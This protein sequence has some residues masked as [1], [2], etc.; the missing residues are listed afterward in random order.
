MFITDNLANFGDKLNRFNSTREFIVIVR[1]KTI[2]AE[3]S[4]ALK[5]MEN[6]EHNDLST[7]YIA[8]SDEVKKLNSAMKKLV[9]SV[10]TIIKQ[11]ASIKV[12]ATRELRGLSKFFPDNSASVSSG[13]ITS[14]EKDPTTVVVRTKHQKQSTR[15]VTGPV[16][17]TVPLT[18]PVT[19]PATVPATLT[20][21]GSGSQPK[22]RLGAGKRKPSLT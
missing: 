15:H 22:T 8:D 3:S 5:R 6:P 13:T 1:P 21:S 4:S 17:L 11:H 14:E 18:V 20:G 7:G 2:N 10:R 12:S 16:P 9:T 19:L